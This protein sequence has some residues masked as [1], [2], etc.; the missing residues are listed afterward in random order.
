MLRYDRQTKSDLVALYDIRPGNGAGPFLQP[1]SPHGANL[2]TEE[3]SC[4]QLHYM[5]AL[6]KNA[7]TINSQV[8]SFK[9]I[10]VQLTIPQKPT[11][12]QNDPLQIN[13]RILHHNVLFVQ[14]TTL[15]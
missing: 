14:L 5:F 13:R 1:R 7:N 12:I 3:K 6:N 10:L 9:F 8:T 15:I 2:P 4:K 11:N